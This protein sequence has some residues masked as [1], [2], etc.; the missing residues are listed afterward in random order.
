MYRTKALFVD[1]DG[2]LIT[3]ISGRT[4]PVGLSDWKFIP[5]TVKAIKEYHDNNYKIIIVTNQ[6]G[7]EKGFVKERDIVNK[8]NTICIKLEKKL[9]IRTTDLGYIYCSKMESFNRK[10]NP[11]MAYEI[12]VEYELNLG[13]CVML[14]DMESDKNFAS[15]A[16]IKYIDIQDIL[17]NYA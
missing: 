17:L 15:N 7:I 16:G 8:L 13:D 5:E 6:E 1:M 9:K 4:F 12:A 10:P 2:T 11:G 14:G 3:T